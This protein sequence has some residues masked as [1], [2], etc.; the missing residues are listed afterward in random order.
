MRAADAWLDEADILAATL[1]VADWASVGIVFDDDLLA[2][3]DILVA[4]VVMA[5]AEGV[6]DAVKATLDAAAEG[7]VPAFVVVIAHVVSAAGDVYCGLFVFGADAFLI[8]WSTALVLD[9]VGWVGAAA[10]VALGD[11]DLIV[12][13]GDVVC[14]ATIGVDIY[15]CVLDWAL[16]AG[17]R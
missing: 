16:V 17:G 10:V 7:M 6:D 12:F 2:G 14:A 4:V 13:V 8:D 11:V 3:F 1:A 5:A 9:V 15:S